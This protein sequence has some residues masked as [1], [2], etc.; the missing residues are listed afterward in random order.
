M[1]FLCAVQPWIIKDNIIFE[2]FIHIHGGKLY[3]I[4]TIGHMLYV[5]LILSNGLKP[6]FDP[7]M[8]NQTN[9]LRSIRCSIEHLILSRSIELIH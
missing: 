1:L 4:N 7:I 6:L 3:R 2:S 5:V 9:S 8:I